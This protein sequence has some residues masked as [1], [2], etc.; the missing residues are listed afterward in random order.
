MAYEL[1]IFHVLFCVVL[2]ERGNLYVFSGGNLGGR[3][4]PPPPTTTT[5]TEN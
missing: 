3:G 5:S 1:N 4:V 2:K